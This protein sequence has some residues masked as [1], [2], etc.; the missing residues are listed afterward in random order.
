MARIVADIVPELGNPIER[1]D[2]GAGVF[3]TGR[4]QRSHAMAAWQDSYAVAVYTLAPG[5]TAV[6]VFRD[7]YI[8]R[9]GGPFDQGI[10]SGRNETWIFTEIGDAL[11]SAP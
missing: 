11:S 2:A 7:V 8:S 9:G 6:W 10:S 3:R 5:R 1:S 4:A